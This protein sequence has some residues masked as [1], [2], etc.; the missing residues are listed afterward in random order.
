MQLKNMAGPVPNSRPSDDFSN[1]G[2]SEAELPD[3]EVPL[4]HGRRAEA[5]SRKKLQGAR[6]TQLAL[7]VWAA[8]ATIGELGLFECS[9]LD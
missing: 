5:M 1:I 3:T 6:W 4:L 7:F 8:V 2:G 9:F